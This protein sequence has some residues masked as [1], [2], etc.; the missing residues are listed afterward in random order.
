MTNQLG[1]FSYAVPPGADRTISLSYRAYADDPQPV[2]VFSAYVL[3]RPHVTLKISPR[4]THNGGTITCWSA[5]PARPGGAR[6]PR[7]AAVREVE[8]I[9]VSASPFSRTAPQR[10]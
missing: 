9:R 2:A 1:Q 8:E 3:V 6:S 7:P 4:H 5:R 10:T